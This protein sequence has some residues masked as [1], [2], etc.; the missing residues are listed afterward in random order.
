MT[1]RLYYQDSYQREF[2]A[3]VVGAEGDRIYLDRT[4]FY[5]ES[6]GQPWD[7]G[8][9]AGVP[10]LEVLD[11]DD[12]IAHRMA[13]AV[14]AAEGL[15]TIDFVRRFDHMQQHT[16]QHL[17]S[18]VAAAVAGAG[19]VSFHMGAETSTIDLSVPSLDERVLHEIERQAN[20]VVFENRGVA[21]S[22]EDAAEAEGLR[23]A[24][25]RAGTLRIVT[26]EGLDRS[27]C[28]GTHVR[29]TGEI[30]PILLRRVDKVRGNARLEFVC[31]RRAVQRARA[32][33]DELARTAR[34]FSCS[35]DTAARHAAA[36]AERCQE[37]EKARL[38]LAMERARREGVDRHAAT[39]PDNAGLR[40][41]L[42]V[43]ESGA[44]TE[45]LRAEASGFVS[46]P[47]AVAVIASRTPPAVLVAAS[48]D[49]GIDAGKALRTAVSAHGGRGGGSPCMAQGTVGAEALDAVL[50]ALSA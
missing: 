3:R 39:A 10:V 5:P 47:R 16:G 18:A 21:V 37:A 30:G 20:E 49:A 34:V 44:I 42:V 24:S 26:I 43:V 9:F 1:E 2:T 46:L 13:G 27:A 6:G 12:R 4:A 7:L 17:L 48:P 22:F 23:K 33:F 28:G 8:S 31:G 38:K 41:W 19:T 50:G 29:S 40:R 45:E 14:T 36:V 15:G 35:L 32:D 25:G 11:Q